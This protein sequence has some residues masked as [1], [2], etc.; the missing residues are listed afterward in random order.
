MAGDTGGAQS[1]PLD[2]AT[3]TAAEAQAAPG[4]KR[5]APSR[6]A[7]SESSSKPGRPQF[8]VTDLLPAKPASW[9]TGRGPSG[10]CRFKC[11]ARVIRRIEREDGSASIRVLHG[12]DCKR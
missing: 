9:Y 4:T 6:K 5:S 8:A 11:G 3:V 1:N 12:K 10:P 7:G 2:R